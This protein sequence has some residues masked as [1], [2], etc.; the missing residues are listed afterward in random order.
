MEIALTLVTLIAIAIAGSVVAERYAV[1]T[2]LLLIVL[3]AAASYVPFVPDFKL[4]P[5]LVLVGLLPPLLY[6]A[7]IQT[8]LIDFA[9]NRRPIA[10]LSIGLVLFTVLGVGA[11]AHHPHHESVDARCR[12]VVQLGER[13]LVTARRALQQCSE[14]GYRA[15]RRP[16]V[17]GAG[18]VAGDRIH[19]ADPSGGEAS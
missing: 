14:V 18:R 3:G 13:G 11:V 16:L 2:P 17:G 5:T 9:A 7:S 19:G 6:A 4:T 12:G 1:S 10:M 15:G 8:S